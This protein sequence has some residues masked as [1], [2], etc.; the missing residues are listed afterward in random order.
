M[1]RAR[2]IPYLILLVLLVGIT[3]L[4][5]WPEAARPPPTPVG[6]PLVSLG[7]VLEG[8]VDRPMALEDGAVLVARTLERAVVDPRP[9]I[10][11]ALRHDAWPAQWAGLLAVSRYGESDDELAQALVPLLTS[12]EARIRADAARAAAYLRE[13][14]FLAVYAA[15]T[16]LLGD[17]V[18]GPRGAALGTLGR[19]A[20]QHPALIP[21]FTAALAD[22]E[23]SIRAQAAR[24]LAQIELQEQVH[25]GEAAGVREALLQALAAEGEFLNDEIRIYAVMAL[26]R[27]GAHAGPA[28]PILLP[29]LESAD[30]LL[31]GQA[32]TAL[33]SIGT[34][35]LPALEEVLAAEEGAGAPS[36]LWALRLMGTPGL[37][38]IQDALGHAAPM[39]RV[40]AAQQ[41]WE[42][43]TDVDAA[44][45]VLTKEA[46]GQSPAVQLVAIRVLGRMGTE[47]ASAR[48][49][50]ERLSNAAEDPRVREA[51]RA[52]AARLRSTEEAGR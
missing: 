40:L 19:R 16:D 11:E 38:T 2:A 3:T 46:E 30:P 49:A 34:A 12:S 33:G 51:A 27:L 10:L 18:P 52:A 45:G 23:P 43:E 4:F 47:G 14:D 1:T 48:P 22:A 8:M 35:A 32:A 37:A 44:L 21:A 20:A 29:F 5:L 6:G 39:V 36:L 13:S 31:R 28:V 26:G 41:L 24:A 50:L 25:D 17:P 9:A 42:L 7:P 15:L